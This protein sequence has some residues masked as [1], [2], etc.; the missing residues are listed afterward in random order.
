MLLKG[1]TIEK[2]E[3]KPRFSQ[4]GPLVIVGRDELLAPV[5]PRD[6]PQANGRPRT[7]ERDGK[8][9]ERFDGPHGSTL[10]QLQELWILQVFF[11]RSGFKFYICYRR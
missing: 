6:L 2:H 1:K 7:A 8:T 5:E 10:R 3:R 9:Q 11:C 4:D